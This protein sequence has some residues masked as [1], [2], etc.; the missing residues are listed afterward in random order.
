MSFKLYILR[1][2]EA[3]LDVMSRNKTFPHKWIGG[4]CYFAVT[5]SLYIIQEGC[6]L[7]LGHWNYLSPITCF[8]FSFFLYYKKKTISRKQ[9]WFGGPCLT[10][11]CLRKSPE[12]LLQHQPRACSSSC[13]YCWPVFVFLVTSHVTVK[14]W[15]ICTLIHV[16]QSFH[17]ADLSDVGIVVTEVH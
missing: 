14:Q 15:I 2:F 3:Q 13:L 4:S 10:L 11:C 17:G 16:W 6:T 7:K 5:Y 12:S 9:Q 1:N 8:F